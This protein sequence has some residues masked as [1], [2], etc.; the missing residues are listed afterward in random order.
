MFT[1]GFFG[2]TFFAIFGLYGFQEKLMFFPRR[3]AN[4]RPG[5]DGYKNYRAYISA[6]GRTHYGCLIEPPDWPEIADSAAPRDRS[7][8]AFYLVFLG[9]AS[10]SRDCISYFSDMARISRCAFFLVDYRGYGFN[11]GQP[12]EAGLTADGLG[13][14][15][16]LEKEGRFR[17]GVGVI[18]VSMGG[19]VTFAV[20]SRRPVDRIITMATYTSLDDMARKQMGWPLCLLCR[21]HFP[22]EARMGAIAARPADERPAEII[23][24]HGRRDGLIP[25]AQAKALHAASNGVARLIPEDADHVSIMVEAENEL[26]ELLKMTGN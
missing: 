7:R 17:R 22:N 8:P 25:F 11:D 16:T 6:D 19:G 20:A 21:N 14:Y 2:L 13:A 4:A 12:N 18:G 26:R 3:Y 24:F 15:D 1:A 9:N 10:V 23:L 5:D